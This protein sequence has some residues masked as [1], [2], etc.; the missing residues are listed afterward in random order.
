MT[1]EMV[2]T[3]PMAS[4]MNGGSVPPQVAAI[5]VQQ[6]PIPI[7]LIETMMV[8]ETHARSI[9]SCMFLMTR[10]VRLRCIKLMGIHMSVA[11]PGGLSHLILNQDGERL[12]KHRYTIA[13]VLPT[14]DI[15]GVVVDGN[16]TVT[17][18]TRNSL[19]YHVIGSETWATDQ[20]DAVDFGECSR[21][22]NG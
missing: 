3:F 5:I 15:L 1:T 13:N 7:S 11:S 17:A 4:A 16:G 14:N 6:F 8:K 20:P 22:G 19:I 10:C 18:R 9:S 2:T 21:V 12:A